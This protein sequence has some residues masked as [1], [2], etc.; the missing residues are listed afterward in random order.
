VKQLPYYGAP[1]RCP[2]RWFDTPY[3]WDFH[4]E[5]SSDPTRLSRWIFY[6]K[7][8][9]FEVLEKLK[10]AVLV[11]TAPIWGPLVLLSWWFS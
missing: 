7:R 5:P 10:I 4:V 6:F 3:C 11:V 2:S 8:G 9:D 1:P